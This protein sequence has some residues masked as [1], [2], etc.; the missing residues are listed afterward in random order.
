M[1]VIGGE[2]KTSTRFGYFI[3]RI[4]NFDMILFR[5]SAV[6]AKCMDPQ[7]RIL[8]ESCFESTHQA[9]ITFD[10]I[11]GCKAGVVVACMYPGY[12]EY[13][14]IIEKCGFRSVYAVMGSGLSYMV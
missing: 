8:L 14:R 11:G 5:M 13:P 1:D 6:E 7:Q 12:S 10:S 3:D 2:G 9:D 4:M